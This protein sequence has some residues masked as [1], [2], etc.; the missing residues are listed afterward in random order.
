MK[1][2]KMVS[3]WNKLLHPQH[4]SVSLSFIH[5]GSSVDVDMASLPPITARSYSLQEYMEIVPKADVSSPMVDA[6]RTDPPCCLPPLT[7]LSLSE[8]GLGLRSFALDK[9]IMSCCCGRQDDDIKEI[10]EPALAESYISLISSSC[11]QQQQ[12]MI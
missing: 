6:P 9:Q 1:L 7:T 12:D 2:E 10:Y 4:G 5:V 11:L 8:M 3:V